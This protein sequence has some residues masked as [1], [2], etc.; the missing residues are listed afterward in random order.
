[1]SWGVEWTQWTMA[2]E[3]DGQLEAERWLTGNEMVT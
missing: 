1:M 3:M 2:Q